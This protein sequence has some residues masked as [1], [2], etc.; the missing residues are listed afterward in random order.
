MRRRIIAVVAGLA[1]GLGGVRQAQAQIAVYGQPNGGVH[2]YGQTYYE[3]LPAYRQMPVAS[4][5]FGAQGRRVGRQAGTQGRYVGRQM[6][7]Q[8]RNVG[9]PVNPLSPS[10]GRT[11]RN[12]FPALAPPP[13]YS[14]EQAAAQPIWSESDGYQQPYSDGTPWNGMPSA[15][16]WNQFNDNGSWGQTAGDIG[17]GGGNPA[18]ISGNAGVQP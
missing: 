4:R 12:Q 6:G 5:S 15:N 17:L 3:T 10:V 16:D 14:A 11:I 18:T 1:L 2:V 8:G 7:A 13:I 9:R